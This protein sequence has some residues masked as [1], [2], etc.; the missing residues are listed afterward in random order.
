[1]RLE[2]VDEVSKR[3]NRDLLCLIVE[4]VPG[5]AKTILNWV[6]LSLRL[7][8]STV[9]NYAF[10]RRLDG[11]HDR[12]N[13]DSFTGILGRQVY[14]ASGHS[15]AHET[16]RFHSGVNAGLLTVTGFRIGLVDATGDR[17]VNGNIPLIGPVLVS[18]RIVL[19]GTGMTMT[20]HDRAFRSQYW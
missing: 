17:C 20:A 8:F 3:M 2:R 14:G 12:Q 4:H 15:V 16:V 10:M 13:G 5:A 9:S 11:Q 18:G 7:W 19:N 6:D 1:M